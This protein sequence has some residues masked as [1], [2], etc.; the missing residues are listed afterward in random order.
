MEQ[1]ANILFSQNF[2]K[3]AF[4]TQNATL[5]TASSKLFHLFKT[6]PPEILRQIAYWIQVRGL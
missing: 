3:V 4:F 1:F 2:S 5:L 6:S